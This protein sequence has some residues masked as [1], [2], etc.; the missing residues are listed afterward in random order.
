MNTRFTVIFIFFLTISFSVRAGELPDS[1]FDYAER[2]TQLIYD[3]ALLRACQKNAIADKISSPLSMTGVYF[4]YKKN[5]PITD[6]AELLERS[7]VTFA[8]VTGMEIGASTVYD[9]V[10][11]QLG[12]EFIKQACIEAAE[13]A[14]ESLE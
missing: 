5:Y 1:A 3:V 8:L 6:N 9:S 12:E 2:H 13:K 10:K 11:Q 4:F 7:A 14:L